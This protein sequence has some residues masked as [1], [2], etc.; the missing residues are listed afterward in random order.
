MRKI[1]SLFLISIALITSVMAQIIPAERTTNWKLAGLSEVITMPTQQVDITHFG[2]VGDG[3]TLNDSAFSV[4]KASLN[5]NA[6]V[7]YFPAGTFKFAHA[8]TLTDSVVLKGAGA[9][10]SK[11]KFD[12]GGA[13][14]CITITGSITSAIDTLAA[15]GKKDSTSIVLQNGQGVTV[16]D[17]LMISFDDQALLYS[18]WAYGTVAQVVKVIAKN[19][20]RLQLASPL[21][22]DYTTALHARIAII[23]P[24]K[25][26]GIECLSLERLDQTVDQTDM[27]LF[28]Y[29]VNCWVRNIESYKCNFGHIVLNYSSNVEIYGSFF[30]EAFAYGGN[31]QGYGVVLQQASGECLIH[32]N[33]FKHLRHSMLIQSGANGNVFAYNYSRENYWSQFPSNTAGDIVLHGNYPFMNLF[34]GNIVQNLVIDNSH[35]AN[36]P[37][38]T[39]FRNRSELYG[40]YMSA[41]TSDYQNIVGTEIVNT[42]LGQYILQGS[43]NFEYSNNHKGIIKPSGTDLL[44]D[45]SYYLIEKPLYLLNKTLPIIG[46]PSVFNTGTNPAKDRWNNGIYVGCDSLFITF[47]PIVTTTKAELIYPNPTTDWLTV[48]ATVDRVIIYDL[49]GKEMMNSFANQAQVFV[50]GLKSGTYIIHL[51]SKNNIVARQKLMKI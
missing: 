27:I 28:N 32:N 6:G 38:N 36:G 46:Y 50:T 2:G 12:L 16:G 39:L 19:G 30:A 17:Y 20:N 33:I 26:V 34:E 9:S 24:A 40:F 29:A 35:G 41:T 42:S 48:S 14:D 23:R 8:I 7:I 25:H 47:K 43:N 21:R 51:I 11:I 49:T 10:A 44:S 22:I 4:A 37:Y 15:D 18:S 31:G 45:T 1:S 13:G 5:G 3:T